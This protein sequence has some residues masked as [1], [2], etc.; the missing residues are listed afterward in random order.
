M[1]LTVIEKQYDKQPKTDSTEMNN[2]LPWVSLCL[3]RFKPLNSWY[4]LFLSPLYFSL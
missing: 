1:L 4:V 3:L 2:R